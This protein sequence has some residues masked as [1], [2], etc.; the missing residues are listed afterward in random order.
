MMITQRWY[1]KLVGDEGLF[2]KIGKSDDGVYICRQTKSWDGQIY[3]SFR[4]FDSIVSFF[5][6]M[7]QTP[8]NERCFFEVIRGDCFQKPYFDIDID[9]KLPDLGKGLVEELKKAILKD[10]RIK[11]ENILVFSSHGERKSSYHVII[12]GWCNPNNYSNE[13]YCKRVIDRISDDTTE[14]KYIDSLVYK[15]IQQ[16]RT[17]GSTK[18]DQDRFKILEGNDIN[19]RDDRRGFYKN[20]FR[21]FVTTTKSCKILMFLEKPKATWD[22]GNQKDL[23][24]SEIESIQG[25]EIIKE[26][27]FEP[28]EI[29]GRMIPLK[30]KKKSYCK[31]CD[32][33]HENE[34]P[35]LTIDE[36]SNIYFH[37]RRTKGKELI[38]IPSK[39]SSISLRKY[40]GK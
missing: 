32:R 38:W 10:T 18:L 6:F 37:C 14:K 28:Q 35:F 7:M 21:S 17:L 30:R 24:S 12:D 20:L 22:Q 33:V 15:S 31:L 4:K 36:D 40:F 3:R 16:L 23:S 27:Y 39:S 1:S 2:N 9:E 34:N 8:K 19:P 13:V 5:D 25:L 11:E 26:E 29:I